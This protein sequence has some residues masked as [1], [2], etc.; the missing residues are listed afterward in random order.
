MAEVFAEQ[1]GAAGTNRG[2]GDQCIELGHLLAAGKFMGVEHEVGVGVEDLE[3][4]RG[5]EECALAAH[6]FAR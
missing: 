4:G 6:L 2:N 1:D 3:C 5:V